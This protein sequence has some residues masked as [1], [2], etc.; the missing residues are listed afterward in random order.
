MLLSL[1]TALTISCQRDTLTQPSIHAAG[2]ITCYVPGNIPTIMQTTCIATAEC[3]ACITCYAGHTLL[4][5]S[6]IN[7]EQCTLPTVSIPCTVPWV[8]PCMWAYKTCSTTTATYQQQRT[9]SMCI[10]HQTT[11]QHVLLEIGKLSVGWL[12]C[13]G[14]STDQSDRCCVCQ[15]SKTAKVWTK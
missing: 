8:M 7:C 1:D 6:N 10:V 15:A 14:Y 5:D 12:P 4:H 2:A 13:I 9:P 3:H 11:W